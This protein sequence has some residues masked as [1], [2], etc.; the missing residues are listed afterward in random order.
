MAVQQGLLETPVALLQRLKDTLQKHTNIVP[1]SQEEEIILKDKFLTQSPPD[2]CGN[3]QKLVA[4]GSR[5]LD[6]LV[7]IA[8]SIYY[9]RY[10]EKEK[11]NLEREKRK[12]KWQEALITAFREACLGQSP[13]RGH[14]FNVDRQVILGGSALEEATSRTLSHLTGKTLEVTLSLVPKGNKTRA[15]HP[16]TVS[17]VS[18]PGSCNHHKTRGAPGDTYY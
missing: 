16:M 1:E 13:N 4:E 9:N 11:E 17:G 2:I 3:L 14:A 12:D 10:L 6:Q 18:H 8:T 7:R 15:S 5:K